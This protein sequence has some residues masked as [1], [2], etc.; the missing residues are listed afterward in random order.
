MAISPR[1]IP[2]YIFPN[3]L[4]IFHNL[5]FAFFSLPK[6]PS[7]LLCHWGSDPL[8]RNLWSV[9]LLFR[10]FLEKY[11]TQETI[12]THKDRFCLKSSKNYKAYFYKQFNFNP[13][14]EQ[15][16]CTLCPKNICKQ[17]LCCE[18]GNLKIPN[19]SKLILIDY[20][21]VKLSP[22]IINFV[23][24]RTFSNLLGTFLDKWYDKSALIGQSLYFYLSLTYIEIEEG[25]KFVYS[26]KATKFCEISTLLLST[27]HTYRCRIRNILWPSQNIWTLNVWRK[28]IILRRNLVF[29]TIVIQTTERLLTVIAPQLCVHYYQA[30][31]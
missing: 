20:I 23:L 30:K 18:I 3:L 6:T 27:V 13:L 26:K 17:L 12:R 22:L 2:S 1:L 5:L 7:P 4:A 24:L 8:W 10:L 15:L 28:H 19:G 31:V 9:F 21:L 25:I 11:A 16:H 29:L 14:L